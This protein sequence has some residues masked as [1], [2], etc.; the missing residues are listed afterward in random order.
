MS[1]TRT[2]ARSQARSST[3]YHYH[4][5]NGRCYYCDTDKMFLRADV[6]KHF[7]NTNR[8]LR[9]TFDHIKLA[10]KGGTY[11]RHNGVCACAWCNNLRG[12]MDQEEF[13]RRFDEIKENGPKPGDRKKRESAK[14]ILMKWMNSFLIARFAMQSDLTVQNLFDEYVEKIV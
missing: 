7:Y 13:I 5:Q 9:A 12:T 2:R 3:L 8:H 1:Q 6:S 14:R 11:A 10:S 4:K